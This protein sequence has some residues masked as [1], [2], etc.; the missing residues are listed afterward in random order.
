MSEATRIKLK[1]AGQEY[2]LKADE[3]EQEKLLETADAVSERIKQLQKAGLGSIQRAATMAAFQFAY[4]LAGVKQEADFTED[5]DAYL[6]RI[7][8]L[9]GQ[10]DEVLQ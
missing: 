9:I 5:S 7:D 2:G 10:I 8:R 4:E 1:I 6:D 3:S